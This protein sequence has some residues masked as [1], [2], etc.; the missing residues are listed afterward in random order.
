MKK[1]YPMR[2]V[3][4]IGLL[5]IAIGWASVSRC[6]A[7]SNPKDRLLYWKTTYGELS[8]FKHV[9]AKRAHDIFQRVLRAAGT[10]P[11]VEPRLLITQHD[12]LGISL[13]IAIPDG[14]I[15][16]SPKA[17]AL[18]FRDPHYADDRL[19]FVLGHEIAHQL[20]GDFWHMQFFQ[21][22][23]AVKAKP[24]NPTGLQWLRARLRTFTAQ[25][26]AR[27][28][29]FGLVYAA[30]E[31]QA[32]NDGIVYAA[33]AGFNPRAIVTEDHTVNFFSD[34]LRALNPHRLDP[35]STSPMS[36][37][38]RA[39]A[40]T[41][42]LRRIINDIDMFYW[43]VRFYQV[44]DY[45]RAILAFHHF[46][47]LFPS[48]EVYQNLALS[49]HQLAL[50]YACPTSTTQHLIPFKLTLML[51][52]TTHASTITLTS[53]QRSLTTDLQLA[54]QHHMDQAAT[55]YQRAQAQQPS[56]SLTAN[57]LGILFLQRG[58]TY[59]AI[60]TLQE[61]LTA[62]PKSPEIL[63]HLGVAFFLEDQP[64]KA[65]RYFIQA[66]QL[67]PTYDAPLFNLGVMA[68]RG[69]RRSE[70][71]AYW[72]TYLGLDAKGP[73]TEM[74]NNPHAHALPCGQ[75][76][77]NDLSNRH[78]T[79]MGLHVQAQEHDR[80]ASWGDPI[81]ITALRLQTPPLKATQYG[82]GV[83]TLSHKQTIQMIGAVE[84]YEGATVKG[85]RLGHTDEEV[86]HRYGRPDRILQT[87]HDASWV[88]ET[89]GIAFQLRNQQV[90]SW[91]LF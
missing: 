80:P 74:V 39:N 29:E 73:W 78:E 47:Q 54:A 79:I 82:H 71:E 27:S 13:P 64:R 61:A 33:I 53:G 90:I 68:Y 56:D 86:Q 45:K 24:P 31:L 65:R 1:E 84:G 2:R 60:A 28:E 40:V 57:N 9:Q 15:I 89:S 37:A 46:L 8:P 21:A 10:R 12:P 6:L 34:W 11:G 62:M 19:A 22:L 25:P 17:L 83:M 76:Q 77:L 26:P 38:N 35:T 55:F 14:S 48:P 87:T 23:E 32:D 85:I 7:A 58:S 4:L 43:G 70:A 36:S 88:Y 18:A 49:H 16:L 72:N 91:L 51:E 50:T 41:K 75:P 59:K 5:I 69:G 20:K 81:K 63:N 42:R 3:G 30:R 44:S 66:R 52:A 67:A